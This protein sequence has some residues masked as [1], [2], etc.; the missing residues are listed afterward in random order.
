MDKV[1]VEIVTQLSP[2]SL[3]GNHQYPVCMT[4]EVRQVNP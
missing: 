3:L 2:A 1:F 4:A